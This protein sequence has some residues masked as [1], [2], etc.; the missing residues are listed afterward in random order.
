VTDSSVPETSEAQTTSH[1]QTDS[2]EHLMDDELT[3]MYDNMNQQL[4]PVINLDSQA[5]NDPF[6]AA[7][8][9]YLQTETL[10]SDSALATSVLL[11]H[12]DY[13]IVDQQLFHLGR[14]SLKKRLHLLTPRVQQLYIPRNFRMQI[15]QSVHEFSHFGFLKCY[16][17]AKQ[18][19]YWV[20]MS[21]DFK[22]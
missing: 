9:Q 20:N 1:V 17:T 18:R 5:E 19:F 12:Q 11:R 10:P 3:R 8:I 7:M 16:L 6:I 2:D 21:S 4:V 15:M 22:Q 13:L 14:P